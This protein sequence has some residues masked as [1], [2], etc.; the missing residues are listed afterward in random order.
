MPGSGFKKKN[1]KGEIMKIGMALGGGAAYGYAH[2]GVLKVF[3]KYG[4]KPDIITGTSVGS[5]VGGAIASGFTIEEFEKLALEFKWSDIASLTIPKE[6]LIDL[7]K[8]ETFIE[9]NFKVKKIQD[10]KIKFAAVV[11]DLITATAHV[12]KEGPIAPA[13]RAS[14][15]IPGIFTPATIG[16]TICVDGGIVDNVPVAAAREMG[17]DFVIAVDVLAGNRTD[18][19]KHRDIFNLVW[20]SWQ[21]AIINS[22]KLREGRGGEADF[23]ISPE[24]VGIGPFDIHRKEDLIKMGERSA[25]KSVEALAKIIG[26]KGSFMGKIKGIFTKQL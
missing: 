10:T 21:V 5:L 18:I 13:I 26:E 4:I 14:C 16:G 24:I 3:E 9:K 20:R 11:T 15:S 25:E 12:I 17:A 19:S 8:I 2:I 1:I 22:T 7:D 23:T 6:G